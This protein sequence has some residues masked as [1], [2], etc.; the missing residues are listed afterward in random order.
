M[1]VARPIRRGENIW[2]WSRRKLAMAS[3]AA[4]SS[5]LL[6][7][8][9][10]LIAISARRNWELRQ[11]ANETLVELE[12]QRAEDFFRADNPASALSHLAWVLRQFPSSHLAAERLL[13]ALSYRSF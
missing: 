9:F 1:I 7:F 8:L 4:V 11:R 3:L 10:C 2:R 13:S 5:L 6:I 12:M